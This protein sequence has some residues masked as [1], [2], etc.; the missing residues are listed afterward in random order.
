MMMK[1]IFNLAFDESFMTGIKPAIT[2][3]KKKSKLPRVSKSNSGESASGNGSGTTK[4]MWRYTLEGGL[5]KLELD[6]SKLV[7]N[8]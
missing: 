6:P 8:P 2:A 7:G 1:D 3:I 5:T 4:T